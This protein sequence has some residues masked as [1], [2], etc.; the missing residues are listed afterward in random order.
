MT[1]GLRSTVIR[2][3]KSYQ[4][5]AILLILSACGAPPST[6]SAQGNR[7]VATDC[8]EDDE[9]EAAL[10]LDEAEEDSESESDDTC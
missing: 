5:W 9:S 8:A 2:E 6:K 4:T 1:L 10:R 3:S 7:Q